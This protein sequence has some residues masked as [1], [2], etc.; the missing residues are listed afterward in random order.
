MH[1]NIFG[2]AAICT[3]HDIDT[4]D[5]SISRQPNVVGRNLGP[6]SLKC[7][8][9]VVSTGVFFSANL[10][11]QNTPEREFASYCEDEMNCGT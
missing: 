10:A 8:L 11:P 4:A 1:S 2:M 5:E 9:E 6:F 3:N 7:F